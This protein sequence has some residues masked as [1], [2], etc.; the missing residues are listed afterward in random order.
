MSECPTVVV[1]AFSFLPSHLRFNGFCLQE[2]MMS[3][4]ASYFT[5][6]QGDCL[7]FLSTS[8]TNEKKDLKDV[9]N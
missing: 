2:L 6:Y 8:R 3:N 4:K 9:A 1:G 7:L 5:Y